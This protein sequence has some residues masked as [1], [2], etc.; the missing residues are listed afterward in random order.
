MEQ[1]NGQAFEEGTQEAERE[2]RGLNGGFLTMMKEQFQDEGIELTKESFT[3]AQ[4]GSIQYQY[5]IK[6]DVDQQIKLFVYP[7]EET[8]MAQMKELYGGAEK[9]GGEGIDAVVFEDKS[10]A[11]VYL[12]SGENQGQYEEQ[13]RMIAPELLKSNELLANEANNVEESGGNTYESDDKK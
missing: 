11:L 4:D 2:G 9:N 10:A 7:D 8:R 13:M 5:L 12:S 1:Y 6:D 3:E